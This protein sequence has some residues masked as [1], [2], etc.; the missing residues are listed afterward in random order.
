M[1]LL[2]YKILKLKWIFANYNISSYELEFI[3]QSGDGF[4]FLWKQFEMFYNYWVK[5]N[6][7]VPFH[8]SMS[9]YP[10]DNGISF[11]TMHS[12]VYI[13]LFSV[14][15]CYYKTFMYPRIIGEICQCYDKFKSNHGRLVL[16][17]G[18]DFFTY[19]NIPMPGFIS[20][21]RIYCDRVAQPMGDLKDLNNGSRDVFDEDNQYLITG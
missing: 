19:G 15:S 13:K 6:G 2:L 5:Y 12:T 7:V 11:G 14:S 9:C 16:W 20:G 1:N 10:K 4:I 21:G 17:T 3:K 8:S 18:K